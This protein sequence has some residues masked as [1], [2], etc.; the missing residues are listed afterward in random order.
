VSKLRWIAERRA[1]RAAVLALSDGDDLQPDEADALGAL[2]W[3]VLRRST[4][5]LAF[6]DVLES[7]TV[8]DLADAEPVNVAELEDRDDDPEA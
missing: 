3:I 1:S 5:E 6:A 7:L 4:P 8:G 2:V